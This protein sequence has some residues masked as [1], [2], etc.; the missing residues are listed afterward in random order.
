MAEGDELLTHKVGPLPVL[1]WVGGGAALV[2]V[3]LMISRRSSGGQQLATNQVS[4]LAPTEAEAFGTIE[5][6][7]QDV[8]NALTTLGNNQSYLGGSLASLSGLVTQQGLYNSSQFQNLLNGQDTIE[9]GQ[10]AAADQAT[11]YQNALLAQ[12][13]A[14]ANSLGSQINGVN[15]NVSTWGKTNLDVATNPWVKAWY[16][17]QVMAGLD[18]QTQQYFWNATQAQAQG[19]PLFTLAQ[20]RLAQ[21]MTGAQVTATTGSD[22]GIAPR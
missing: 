5:Q 12:M 10:S 6:Q 9:Q 11:N 2:F 15:S 17:A 16:Q 4:S 1:A 14:Y 19:L 21:T 18:P 20:N 13:L 3:F 8:T 7:Q 22:V